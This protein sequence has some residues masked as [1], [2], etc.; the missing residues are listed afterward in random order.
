MSVK[1]KAVKNKHDYARAVIAHVTQVK[2]KGP[3]IFGIW[4]KIKGFETDTN[5]AG[6]QK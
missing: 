4:P 1:Y 3:K 2:F 5:I 6:L